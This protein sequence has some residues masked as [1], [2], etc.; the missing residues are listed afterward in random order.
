MSL[1]ASPHDTL[2][3]SLSGPITE[4]RNPATDAVIAAFRAAEGADVA[5]AAERA[6]AAQRAWGAASPSRRAEVVCEAARLILAHEE[7][8]V[9]WGIAET[10]GIA[11]KASHEVHASNGHLLAAAA[12][13]TGRD[14]RLARSA[15]PRLSVARRI[16]FGVVGVITPWNFPLLLAM[17]AVAP[18]LVL[19][20]AVLLKPDHQTPVFG[21]ALIGRLFAEAGL[22]D[23]LLTVLPGTA[24]TGA[25]LVDEPEVA[26]IS[27]T[28]STSAG[29]TV[30][31]RAAA[32]LKKVSL[33]LG[34]NN[35]LVVLDDADVAAASS[36]GAW[37]SFFHQGQICMATGRHLVQRSIAEEYAHE[38]TAHAEKLHVG[39]PAHSAV[40]VGPLINATQ[41]ATVDRV[42]SATVRA[43]AQA[44]TGGAPTG[45]GLFY[46]PTVLTG[47]TPEMSAFTEEIFG[48]VASITVFDDLDEAVALVNSDPYGLSAAVLTAAPFR[49]LQIAEQLQVGMVH[50]NDTTINEDPASPFGGMGASGNGGRYGGEANWDEF[51]QWQWLTVRHTPPTYPY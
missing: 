10:G 5:A 47:V 38:L 40:Q 22:P 28:G 19:G 14:G 33:E 16:P 24:S 49:G 11:A 36:I 23:G 20:N 2:F 39:D 8:F 17:R 45:E 25:A 26:M 42:V 3:G 43:G 44:R 12:L 48:P 13:A 18:A 30:G 29:R 46:S 41:L 9:Q 31:S 21:G 35:A 51:T 32:H 37:G 15:A 34:G 4:V 50:V 6:V 27:F 1:L 7:E